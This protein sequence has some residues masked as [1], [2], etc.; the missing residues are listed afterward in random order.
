M[1]T[2]QHTIGIVSRESIPWELFGGPAY[3]VAAL[4]CE[5]DGDT[6]VEHCYVAS[7]SFGAGTC[8]ALPFTDVPSA[9]AFLGA[10]E[11]TSLVD[12]DYCLTIYR[13]AIVWSGIPGL[14]LQSTTLLTDAWLDAKDPS[15]QEEWKL[16]AKS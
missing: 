9:R 11:N 2:L 10:A 12:G 16:F 1:K 3:E 15:T 8:S 4:P 7:A 5:T 14:L 13:A 6:V